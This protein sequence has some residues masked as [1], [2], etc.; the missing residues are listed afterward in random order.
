MKRRDFLRAAG[1]VTA[2][3]VLPPWLTDVA[4]EPPKGP[5][6]KVA[7]ATTNTPPLT[8]ELRSPATMNTV[9]RM[10]KEVYI[11]R[12]EEQLYR[13]DLQVWDGESDI[14]FPEVKGTITHVVLQQGDEA[15]TRKL[16]LVHFAYGRDITMSIHDEPV[17]QMPRGMKKWR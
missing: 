16:P 4:W 15:Y 9:G 17:E 7:L 12:L 6:F 2:A 11:P 1:L 13:T 14:T 10:L 5:E 3:T 8:S